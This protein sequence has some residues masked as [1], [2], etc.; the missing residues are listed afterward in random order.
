MKFSFIIPAY[1]NYKLLHQL[2]WDIYKNCSP[3]YEIVITD[4]GNDQETLDGVEWW[5]SLLPVR[6]FRHNEVGFLLNSN[7]GLRKARGDVLC[8]VSTD[9]R[10]H[11]DIVGYNVG[12]ENC[13]WGGKLLD[14]DTGWNTF[15]GVVYPYL[16]GWLLATHKDTWS[17]LDYF[18]ER[19]SPNDMEDVD[20]STQA[21]RKGLLLR[22]YPE[23]YVSHLGAQTI[24]YNPEREELTKRNKTK[25]YEKW[26]A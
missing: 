20:L 15:N 23:D 19:Y 14:W 11:K 18:D 5:K 2:L 1:N 13:L 26:V 6:H 24:G 25:F 8:L 4:D 12:Y 9:V 21:I 16:E 7:A 22:A 3:C 17:K 10:I